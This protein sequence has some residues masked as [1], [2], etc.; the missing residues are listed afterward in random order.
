MDG[1]ADTAPVT[2]DDVAAFLLDNPDAAGFAVPELH[3]LGVLVLGQRGK[4][5]KLGVDLSDPI[6]VLQLQSLRLAIAL[7]HA[8]RDPDI[9]GFSLQCAAHRF[10]VETRAGWSVAYPQSAHLLREEAQAWQKTPWE[11]A[12][13]FS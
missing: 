2:A 4:L 6:F 9:T 10:H 5:R 3:H 8:R 13:D 11:L 12:L 7:C 1:Q